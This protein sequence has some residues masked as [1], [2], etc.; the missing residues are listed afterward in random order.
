MRI[1]FVGG[2]VRTNE[3]AITAENQ[4]TD[5]TRVDGGRWGSGFSASVS[6]DSTTLSVVW[7]VQ[8]RR[9]KADGTTGNVIDVFTSGAASNGGIQTA[10]LFGAWEVRVGVKT[11]NYSAGTGVAAISW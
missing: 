1:L 11:G 10:S 5:W 6:D 3:A 2:N 9:I 7:T 8:M 4:F